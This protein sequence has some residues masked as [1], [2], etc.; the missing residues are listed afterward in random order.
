MCHSTPPPPPL[1][2]QK[3]IAMG[4]LLLTP[5]F[6][7]GQ[8]PVRDGVYL[9]RTEHGECWFAMRWNGLTLTW[10]A[11]DTTGT[12]QMDVIGWNRPNW[13]K[14]EWRGLKKAGTP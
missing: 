3:G 12:E 10:Y 1:R 2:Q 7:P 9:T 13:P 6:K 4:E 5:W 8:H 11:A 14:Y